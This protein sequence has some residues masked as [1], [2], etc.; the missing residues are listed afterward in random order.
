MKRFFHIMAATAGLALFGGAAAHAQ[1]ETYSF[2]QPH[3]Q[4]LFFADHLGFSQST[5]R[6]H[7]FDGHFVLDR[8]NPENSSVKIVIETASID[9]GL[10]RWD[11]HMKNEDF[12]DVENYPTMTF[13]ST[14]VTVTGENTAD[15]TGDLTILGV[16]K[17][18][19]L[20]VTH[21]KSGE[22]P[23]NGRYIAGFTAHAEI[24]RRE[25]GMDYGYPV[26]GPMVEIRVTVE[27]IRDDEDD[28]AADPT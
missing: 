28:S 2:E 8:D 13:E 25:W 12:F 4:I 9:M 18:A 7:D 22:H 17:P 24:D 27:G 14:G 10:E 16:T 15:V 5:G 11:D 6:F 3:T 26:M 21:N 19:T 1:V 20:H 23:F